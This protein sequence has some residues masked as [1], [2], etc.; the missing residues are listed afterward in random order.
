LIADKTGKLYLLEI[1]TNPGQADF[2][3]DEE[4]KRYKNSRSINSNNEKYNLIANT[5]NANTDTRDTVH[6]IFS[7]EI[8]RAHV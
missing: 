8:G 4:I 2:F 5:A 6:S 7:T 1:N 3:P